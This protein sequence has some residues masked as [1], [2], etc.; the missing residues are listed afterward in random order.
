M[1]SEARFNRRKFVRYL[2]TAGVGGAVVG[3]AVFATT[4]DDGLKLHEAYNPFDY[5]WGFVVD[6]T[7]CI[8]C[9]SCVRACSLEN[10]VPS[11][12][13]RTWVERFEIS[14]KDV[15]SVD[16][17]EGAIKSFEMDGHPKETP[18]VK[19]FFVPKLCNHCA[20]SACTQVCPVGATFHS[21][22]GVVLVDRT[23]CMGCGYCIQ[24]CPY[25]CRFLNHDLG[26]ADKCTLCY[27]RITRGLKNACVLACPV[28]ARLCGNMKDENSAIKKKLHDRRYALLK[29]DLGTQP[30]CYYIGLDLEV[31]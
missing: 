26:V 17:P 5:D 18:I 14:D 31:I 6:T 19:G 23:H 16:S 4:A 27:H 28:G 30:E 10:S 21:P 7:L 11:G 20:A 1:T 2:L 8:G 13:Y 9:G 22:D 24:A 3:R 15:I 29:P 12:Y 25:G